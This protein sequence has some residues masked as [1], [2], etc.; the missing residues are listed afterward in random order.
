MKKYTCY[1]TNETMA[2]QQWLKWYD[3][4]GDKENFASKEDWFNEMVKM[5][6]LA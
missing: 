5:N 4:N 2:K 1:E 6:I 3:E